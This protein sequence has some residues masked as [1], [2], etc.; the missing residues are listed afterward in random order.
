[1][2]EQT[3]WK[4]HTFTLLVFAGI[5]VLCSIFFVLGMLVGRSQGQKMASSAIQQSVKTEA[6][7]AAAEDKQDFTP[8]EATKKEDPV[9][10]PSVPAKT[11]PEAPVVILPPKPERPQPAPPSAGAK[12]ANAVNYQVGAVR[13]PADAE[14]LLSEVKKK[15]FHAFILPPAPDDPNPYFRVQVG[16]FAD[17]IEAQN[18]KKKLEDAGYQ[19]L[20]RK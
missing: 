10:L 6:K 11:A 1:M 13:Q 19:V 8:Y 9:S 20:L 16:P 2:E 7:P 14:K 17:A 4:G 12:A 15:G 3:S 5:V 18:V